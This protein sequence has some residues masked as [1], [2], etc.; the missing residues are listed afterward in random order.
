MRPLNFVEWKI[1]KGAL[2][3]P[4][5]RPAQGQQSAA[6]CLP[7]PATP[8]PPQ[9]AFCAAALPQKC[10]CAEMHRRTHPSKRAPAAE[11]G[12]ATAEFLRARRHIATL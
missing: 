7:G 4:S 12:T 11:Q 6:A 8:V 1:S 10:T 2:R 3:E 5:A 9:S